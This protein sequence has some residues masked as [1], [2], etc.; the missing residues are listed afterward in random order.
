[1]GMLS[2]F[3]FNL[4]SCVCWGKL[5]II[6]IIMILSGLFT[7]IVGVI[8]FDVDWEEGIVSGGVDEQK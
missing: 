1:M 5:W 3:K 2:Q 6:D 7:V 8:M 4:K